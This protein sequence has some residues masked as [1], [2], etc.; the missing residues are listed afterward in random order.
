M[1]KK[2]LCQSTY[3]GRSQD[4]G[5]WETLQAGDWEE[6]TSPGPLGKL[7]VL[8]SLV[9]WKPWSPLTQSQCAH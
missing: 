8:A 6:T 7:P 4:V 1:V 9:V 3:P 2:D 5:R